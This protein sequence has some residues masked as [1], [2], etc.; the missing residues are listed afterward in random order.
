MGID[1]FRFKVIGFTA[2]CAF[3]R[4]AREDCTRTC[5]TFL[6]PEHVRFPE[7]VRPCWISSFLGGWETLTGTLVASFAWVVPLEGMRVALPPESS[8]SAGPHPAAADRH[9]LVAPGLFGCGSSRSSGASVPVIL[10]VQATG[11]RGDQGLDGVDF[12]LGGCELA[13]II[14]P[15]GS[16]KTTLFNGITGILSPSRGARLDGGGE[17]T[18]L[19]PDEISRRGIARTFQISVSSGTD[20]RRQRADR[21][22]PASGTEQCRGSAV[23]DV[24]V[25]AIRRCR[26]PSVP[27][28][29]GYS[30]RSA[31]IPRREISSGGSPVIS[32]PSI[33]TAAAVRAIDPVITLNNVVF[34]DPLGPDDPASSPRPRRKSTPSRAL[35]PRNAG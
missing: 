32:P 9:H 14:G 12:R 5:T 15:N 23:P 8:S 27:G 13:G 33:E 22:P 7:I 17:I 16:G 28:R 29:D 24:R 35:I 25:W 21:P 4:R 20:G 1:T 30:E 34:P 3:A 31:R 26:R 19:P 2:G 10:E 18:G 11:I 6:P